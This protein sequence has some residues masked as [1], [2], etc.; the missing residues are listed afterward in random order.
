MEFF[1]HSQEDEC[2]NDP[3]SQKYSDGAVE[4]PR[5]IFVGIGNTEAGVKEGG[6]GEPETTIEGKT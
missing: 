2:K 6:V 4:L 1:W 3:G 5:M